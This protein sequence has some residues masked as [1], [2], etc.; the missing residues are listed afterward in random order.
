MAQTLSLLGNVCSTPQSLLTGS[1]SCLFCD[2]QLVREPELVTPL[3]SR[4][5]SIRR[6]RHCGTEVQLCFTLDLHSE[7]YQ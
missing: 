7:H 6:E 5:A 1:P 2:E 4:L 3:S